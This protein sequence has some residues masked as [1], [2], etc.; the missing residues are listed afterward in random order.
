LESLTRAALETVLVT[1]E[2]KIE[3]DSLL[4]S[5]SSRSLRDSGYSEDGM[6]TIE[7]SGPLDADA[8]RRSSFA[9]PIPEICLGDDHGLSL[10]LANEAF[11]SMKVEQR[12]QFQRVSLFELNQRKALSAYHQWSLKRLLLELEMG[13]AESVK[14]VGLCT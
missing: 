10:A 14:K 6:S 13:K 9:T 5:P 4:Q 3:T 8:S 2:V 1:G 12:Q 7:L 11:K